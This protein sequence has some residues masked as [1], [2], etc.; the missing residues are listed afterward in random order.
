MALP[1]LRFLDIYDTL[2]LLVTIHICGLFP[3]WTTF[4]VE[5]ALGNLKAL[6]YKIAQSFQ[7]VLTP[8][9]QDELCVFFWLLR[10]ST[11][12]TCPAWPPVLGE[13][14]SIRDGKA[15]S[16]WSEVIKSHKNA[17]IL[18]ICSYAVCGQGPGQ[19]P[20]QATILYYWLEHE[21]GLCCLFNINKKSLICITAKDFLIRCSL[22][23]GGLAPSGLKHICCSSFLVTVKE[24]SDQYL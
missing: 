15:N 8:R 16:W 19:G 7:R 18:I 14:A 2:R 23:A 13:G 4:S 1:F 12:T 20:G 22:S 21:G 11:P 3:S 5:E 24:R 9:S 10:L 17:L 6:K